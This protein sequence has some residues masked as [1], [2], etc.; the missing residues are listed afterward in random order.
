MTARILYTLT[1]C[2]F[3]FF[4]QLVF[5]KESNH[6]DITF[7]NKSYPYLDIETVNVLPDGDIYIKHI[8]NLKKGDCEYTG[9]AALRLIIYRVS[10]KGSPNDSKKL[11]T[12]SDFPELNPEKFNW[13]SFFTQ[14]ITSGR[15]TAKAYMYDMLLCSVVDDDAKGGS[16]TRGVPKGLDSMRICHADERLKLF[17][18]WVAL[19]RI[20]FTINI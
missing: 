13:K 16:E 10:Y 8:K 7:C 12:Y 17:N 18:F 19:S 3:I 1:F 14:S 4:P 6:V 11:I 15:G 2:S 20:K 5:G 9:V